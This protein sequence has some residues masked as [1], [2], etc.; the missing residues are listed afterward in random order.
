MRLLYPNMLWGLVA[1]VVPIAVHLFNFRRHKL[2]Y[3]SNT[4]VLRS[5]QMEN[6]KTRKL[7]HIVTL[8]LRCAFI[9]ALV[10]AFSFPYRVKNQFDIITNESVVGV[11]IDNSMSM[12]GLS[13]RTTLLED[14]RQSARDLVHKLKPSTRYL[15]MTNSFEI[16]NEYPMNQEEMLDQIDKMNTNGAPVRLGEVI[17][18]FGML[19]KHHG[20]VSSTL[21]VYSDFQNNAFNLSGAK[22]DTSM[23]II[24]VP[25]MPESRTN[26]YIDSVWLASPIVQNGFANDLTVR[27]VNQGDKS[28]KGLPV[29]F[30]MNDAM[31]AS[32][33]V[34]LEKNSTVEVTMQFMVVNHG[35]QRC[36]VRLTDY[37][38][39]FDD[40]YHFALN[41]KPVLSVVELGN[42]RNYCPLVFEDDEQFQYVF[43]KPSQL[44]LGQL[45]K[46]NLLIVNETAE[47]NETF[48]QR[49]L[50]VVSDGA[51]L[52]LFPPIQDLRY[53]QY[54]YN[55]LGISMIEIDTNAPSVEGLAK[56]Q[57]F[58]SDMIIDLP[59]YPDLPK[60]KQY[61]RMRTNGK[62]T[63]LLTM[64]NDAPLLL[65]K[66]HGK[67]NVFIFTSTLRPT[68]SNM[69]DNVLF[70]P[71]ML[72]AALMAGHLGKISYTLG[73]DRTIAVNTINTDGDHWVKIANQ[74]QDFEFMPVLETRNN[75]VYLHLN[76]NLPAPGFYQ[77]L[78]NDTVNQ[79]T[80]WNDSRVESR[81]DY[82]DIA[83][84]ETIFSKS[85]FNVA[86]VFEHID[87][88]NSDLMET[89]I[90]QS[91]LWKLFALI[92][93]LAL[94]GE[95]AVLR[96]W[97]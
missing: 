4:S 84:I 69:A 82:A 41:I 53:N 43:M 67:G 21:F 63:T 97:K 48:Q 1:L 42:E 8:L 27:I 66:Q 58:F 47:L 81:M 34:D 51:S 45:I 74:E 55:A 12:S 16:Q 9:V 25:M 61:V 83:E 60:V 54:L 96:F 62:L 80:A 44:D 77:I 73:I 93:L 65:T 2:V 14:A 32:T 40:D 57:P 11:Y 28:V 33:T 20:F 76:D 86:A 52:M 92:A 90:L 22:P 24:A 13:Q 64:Q 19:V 17:D 79:I 89:M 75:K 15:L 7:K 50:D 26:L 88:T 18:R 6:A 3:F 46:P 56:H 23:R 78:V 59:Q 31:A 38:I 10:L 94:L 70:V 39:T 49:L 87:F 36:S 85:G 95:I 5:I 71:M 29:T 91:M 72:K 30:T 37:P 68:W 35:S